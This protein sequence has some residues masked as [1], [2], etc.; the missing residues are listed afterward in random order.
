[1]IVQQLANSLALGGVYALMALGYSLIF[2]VLRLIHFSYGDV[3]VMGGYIALTLLAGFSHS[4]GLMLAAMIVFTTLLGL[5]VER[6]NFR[7]LRN[8]P[9]MTSL[10]ASLGMSLVIENA[11]LLLWGPARRPFEVELPIPALRIGG[12]Q[13][14]GSRVL[15]V[16]VCLLVM[17][18][19]DFLL[20]RTRLGMAIRATILDHD[21]AT[22]MGINRE[23]IVV[24]TFAVGSAL[25]GV[26]MLLLGSMYGVV[27]PLEGYV[28][29]TMVFA[30]AMIGGMGSMPGAVIGG[31]II[32]FTLTMS[33]AYIS[34][35]YSNAITMALLV[36]V[37]IIKPDGILGKRQEENI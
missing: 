19:L 36:L 5:F 30:A 3:M 37:L 15:A 32:G 8:M 4:F 10:V 2:G 1:M 13:L 12:I 7:P 6:V 20:R 25:S 14:S 16:L 24:S 31:L 34:V 21:A 11:I 17:V 18:I 28:I 22:L 9:Y 27:Y 26:A 35:T 33:S 29:G 23:F